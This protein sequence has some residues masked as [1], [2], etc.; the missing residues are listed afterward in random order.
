MVLQVV[1]IYIPGDQEKTTLVLF[2][3]P[4]KLGYFLH[5]TKLHLGKK[6]G[7]LKISATFD[8]LHNDFN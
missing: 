8:T 2:H 4:E 5:P 6:R 3:I 7:N 1:D